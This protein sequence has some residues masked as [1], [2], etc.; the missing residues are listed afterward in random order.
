MEVNLWSDLNF[1]ATAYVMMIMTLNFL[2]NK[3]NTKE[4]DF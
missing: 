4:I 1:K 2:Q 3:K